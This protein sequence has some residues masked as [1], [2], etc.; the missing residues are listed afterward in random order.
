MIIVSDNLK[1][2]LRKNAN[3]YLVINVSAGVVF[4]LLGIAAV[5]IGWIAGTP[6]SHIWIVLAGLVMLAIGVATA[7]YYWK[8][9]VDVVALLEE[10][11][12]R[13]VWVYKEISTGTAYGVTVARFSFVVFGLDD[14]HRVRVRLAARDADRLIEEL[15]AQLRH[16][17]FGY[18][19]E[20]ERRYKNNPQDLRS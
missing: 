16:A 18:S 5:V 20:L 11:P 6:E 13:V 12:E 3:A 17:T 19:A 9:R 7:W 8:T 15:N 14:K 4:A 1:A 10:H 2:A